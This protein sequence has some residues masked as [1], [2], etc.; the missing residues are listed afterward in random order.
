MNSAETMP[1]LPRMSARSE[2]RFM[3]RLMSSQRSRGH[4]DVAPFC[5]AL[6]LLCSMPAS[7]RAESEQGPWQWRGTAY[8]WLPA[9]SGS[10]ALNLGGGTEITTEQI[11]DALDFAF[12]GH[13]EVRKG[14]WGGFTDYIHL[15]F[16]DDQSFE[17]FANVKLETDMGLKGQSWTLAGTYTAIEKPSV[18][19]LVLGG[20]R[21]LNI[22]V[23]VDW[24]ASGTLGFIDPSGATSAG[25]DYWDAII[26]VR[27]RVN[28]V[29]SKWFVPYYLDVG[30]GDSDFTW[31]A[32]TGLGYRFDWGEVTAIYRHFAHDFGSDAFVR[33]LE[34]SGP[35][36]GISFLF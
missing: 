19:L 5:L 1:S 21:Y 31:Q 29:P 7:G 11:L 35:A 6:A 16:Q 8:A 33:D 34:F 14:R 10:T 4:R 2:C 24:Q 23:Q 36:I 3:H 17:P 9:L 15:D 28:A 25:T 26:G 20:L 32:A 13:L 30:A 18:E 22:D 27:G 12:M